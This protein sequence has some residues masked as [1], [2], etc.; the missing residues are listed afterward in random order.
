MALSII[1]ALSIMMRVAAFAAITAEAFADVAAA[2]DP[3]D[4]DWMIRMMV[5]TQEGTPAIEVYLPQSV[6]FGKKPLVRALA[7]PVIGYYALDLSGANKGKPL[8]PVKVSMTEDGKTVIVNQYTR[9]LPPTRIPAGGGTVDFDRRFATDA[10]C[11]PF[12]AQD[13]NCGQ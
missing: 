13:P 10:K 11:G 8:E 4:A 3:T 12:R 9:G 5:C 7:Q 6:V 2:K 1:M